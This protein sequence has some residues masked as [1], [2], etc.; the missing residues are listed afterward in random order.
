M[1]SRKLSSGIEEYSNPID[2]TDIIGICKEYSTLGYKIQY[3]I[4]NIIEFGLED[5]IKNGK[6]KKQS[7]PYIKGFLKMIYN[8][9]LLGD[10][11]SQAMDCLNLI[12]DYE[13]KYKIV[14]SFDI[15][16]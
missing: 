13:K 5:S 16:N 4:E 7:L 3:Q 11:S 15:L 10:A 2:I 9:H 6:V 12:N 8:N 1:I 14:Y